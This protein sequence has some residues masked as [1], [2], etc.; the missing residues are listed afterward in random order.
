MQAS[1]FELKVFHRWKEVV[2]RDPLI[3]A[4]PASRLHVDIE[5]LDDEA[6]L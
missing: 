1:L 5:Q 6:T 2:L 3:L 4:M